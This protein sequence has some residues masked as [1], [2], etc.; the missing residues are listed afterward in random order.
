MAR[1]VYR[2]RS[3]WFVRRF[4][5]KLMLLPVTAA[6]VFLSVYMRTSPFPPEQA[7]LHLLAGVDCP[8]AAPLTWPRR[9]RASP[10]YHARFDED[11]DG[12]AC[13]PLPGMVVEGPTQS[14][15]GAKFLRP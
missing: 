11:G 10:G 8:M 14:R 7:M 13:E 3:W 15:G 1:K 2:I 4:L 6:G 12:I 9:S 5:W